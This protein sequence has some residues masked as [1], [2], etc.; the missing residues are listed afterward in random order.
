MKIT[1]AMI[2]QKKKG[3]GHRGF[4]I[5]ILQRKN[6]INKANNIYIKYNLYSSYHTIKIENNTKILI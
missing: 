6:N 5:W 3:R 4:K 1:F 2:F